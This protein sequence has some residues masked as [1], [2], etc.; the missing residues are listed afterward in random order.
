[1]LFQRP[2]ISKSSG[3]AF[4][5]DPPSS[6][7]LR[8]SWLS[9]SPINLTLLRHWALTLFPDVCCYGWQGWTWTETGK[10]WANLWLKTAIFLRWWPPHTCIHLEETYFIRLYS[11]HRVQK[12]STWN[13]FLAYIFIALIFLLSASLYFSLFSLWAENSKNVSTVTARSPKVLSLLIYSHS[14]VEI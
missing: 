2:Y 3:V 11:L 14:F 8:R 7:R 4:P 6:S 1:M 10:S 9:P 5:P 12:Y 13:C